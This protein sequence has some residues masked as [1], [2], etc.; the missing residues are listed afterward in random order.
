MKRTTWI[1][2]GVLV[3]LVGVFALVRDEPQTRVERT[4]IFENEE[5]LARIELVPAASSGGPEL[6]VMEKREGRWWITRPVESPMEPAMASRFENQL[7][8]GI[9]VD[10]LP[11]E[12]AAAERYGLGEDEVVK[13]ALFAEGDTSP[14]LRLQVGREMTVPQ[15]GARRTFVRLDGEEQI[16]R[17]QIEVGDLVR[18]KL[19]DLRDREILTAERSDI[20]RFEIAPR[21]G[22]AYTLSRGEEEGSWRIE[23]PA[24]VEVALA[25][26]EVS[27]IVS[28]LS[29]LTATGFADELSA[30]E[31]GLEPPFARVTVEADTERHVL[32]VGRT[33]AGDGAGGGGGEATY[34]VKR[35][36]RPYIYR[37]SP[38]AAERLTTSF[39][40]LHERE[41]EG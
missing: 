1:T 39:E 9:N 20:A 31:A 16:Y 3:V 11:I 29:R 24:G 22:T 26:G 5:P 28:A 21:D 4:R 27:R 32:L 8:W 14:R 12:A 18:T 10:D 30:A 23:E 40:A 38:H 33:E 15:T 2:I 34:F 25:T 37:I 17:A 6:V 41:D 35:E 7:F 19:D 36:D 13:V